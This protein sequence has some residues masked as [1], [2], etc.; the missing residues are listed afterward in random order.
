MV[1]GGREYEA[2]DQM[3][4]LVDMEYVVWTFERVEM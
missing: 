1:L 4:E 3:F 2:A